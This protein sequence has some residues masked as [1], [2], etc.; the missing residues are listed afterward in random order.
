[1]RS[2]YVKYLAI[3]LFLILFSFFHFIFLKHLNINLYLLEILLIYVLL[4]VLCRI[5]RKENFQSRLQL[6]IILIVCFGY[7]ALTYMSGFFLGFVYTTYSTRLLG[8]ARNVFYSA[9]FIVLF[10]FMREIIIQKVRYYKSLVALSTVVITLLELLLTLSLVLFSDRKTS[11]ELIIIFVVPCLFRNIF[12]TYSTYHFGKWG[13]ILYHLLMVTTS[14][15]LPIFPNINDYI[16][17]ILLIAH[18][19]LS[20]YLCSSLVAYKPDTI[21]N[22]RDYN[23]TIK[24]NKIITGVIAV[25]LLGMIYLVSDMGRI[26]AM[27]IGSGSMTGA[28]NKGDVAILDKKAQK[29]KVGDIIAFEMNGAI[30]IHRIVDINRGD[31]MYYITKGDANR[32]VDSWK[33]YPELIKGKCIFTVKYIGIPTV[34]LSEYLAGKTV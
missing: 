34:A 15:V 32:G 18:P 33:V 5:D 30:I 12:L 16:N 3:E 22:A 4:R 25:I 27:A 24:R 28:I 23:A 29:Y 19:L 14:Y 31:R 9:A 17:I 13:S 21:Y 8:M 10:E 7:Y 2:Q 11:M 6:L 26:T 1:M 20:I